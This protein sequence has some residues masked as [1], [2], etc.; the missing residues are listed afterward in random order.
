[1]AAWYQQPNSH[2]RLETGLFS[3]WKENLHCETQLKILKCFLVFPLVIEMSC[4]WKTLI[5]RCLCS[6]RLRNWAFNLCIL[7]FTTKGYVDLMY[8]L[9]CLFLLESVLIQE[10]WP[11]TIKVIKQDL[12]LY[13]NKRFEPGLHRKTSQ[14][15]KSVLNCWRDCC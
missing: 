13:R 4:L 11:R 7:V 3:T 8:V 9:L 10:M 6:L 1:M 14:N 5:Y 2:L 12:F 15:V